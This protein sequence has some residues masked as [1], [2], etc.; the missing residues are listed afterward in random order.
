MYCSLVM[1]SV[2]PGVDLSAVLSHASWLPGV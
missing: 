2:M 1:E